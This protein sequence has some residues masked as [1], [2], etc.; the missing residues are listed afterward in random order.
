MPTLVTADLHLAEN[1]RDAYRL[2]FF[3][4]LPA[5]AREYDA[6]RVLVLGDITEAKDGHRA[7]LVNRIVDGFAALAEVAQVYVLLGNHDY[8]SIDVPFYRFLHHLPRVRWIAEPT[9]LKLRGL[10]DCLFLPHTRD[11]GA[12]TTL[13]GQKYAWYFCHQ[14]FGG[15]DLGHGQLAKAGAAPFTRKAGDRVVSGDVHVPQ[16]LGAVTYVGSPYTI[17]FGDD[18]DPRILLL[19][20]TEMLSVPTE[21]PQKV[22]VEVPRRHGPAS[23]A[24]HAGDIVKVRVE[25]PPNSDRSRTDVRAEWRAWAGRMGVEL[26]TVQVVSPEAGASTPKARLRHRAPDADLVRAYVKKMGKGKVTAA[27]GLKIVEEVP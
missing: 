16:Q 14:T 10:G 9:A 12:W 7:T 22:L 26:Y 6:D 13:M 5:L 21:G 23:R 11:V 15:A 25:L 20:G 4:Q 24:P 2:A 19:D 27:A 8:V 18:F 17:D 1:P 3:D